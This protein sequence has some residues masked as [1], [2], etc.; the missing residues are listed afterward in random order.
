MVIGDGLSQ[1]VKEKIFVVVGNIFGIVSVDDQVKMVILVI[2]SQF[3]IVKF[4][5]ILSVIFK[6][7]YGNVNLYNKIFEVNK[8]MLKSLDKIYLG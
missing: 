3:Y 7:V 8:L 2:V 1:E 4:G 5:D 6:Q